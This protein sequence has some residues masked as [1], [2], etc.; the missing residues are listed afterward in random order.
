IG[1][2]I[3]VG[4]GDGPLEDRDA[5]HHDIQRRGIVGAEIGLVRDVSDTAAQG[6]LGMRMD[7]RLDLRVGP[8]DFA[9][10]CGFIGFGVLV[11]HAGTVAVEVDSSD[12]V[13]AGKYQ[14]QLG[15][16]AATD[17]H[18]F[19]A[20]DTGADVSGRPAYQA[21]HAQD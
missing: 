21:Q 4:H 2:Q 19:R 17:P 14:P 11:V 3:L 7:D 12:V 6:V 10:N 16:A 20:G 15:T 8:I 13:Y 1:G 18:L 9:V 5:L